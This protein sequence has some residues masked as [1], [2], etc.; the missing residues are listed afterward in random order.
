M[1]HTGIEG[2]VA[3]VT[4]A[5]QGIGRAVARALAD[6][7]ASVAALDLAEE[8]LRAA[9]AEI[10]SAGGTA[11]AFPCDV[12]DPA[13]VEEAFEAA[14]RSL[15]PVRHAVSVAGVLRTGPGAATTDADWAELV[16]VNATG[17]FH[18]LRA[19]ARRM[20]A[21]GAGTITTVGSNAADTPRADLAA[22]GASKAAAASFTRALGV[23][24]APLGVR[25]NV[26]SPGSTDTPMQRGMWAGPDGAAAVIAGAPDRFRTGIPLG[27][28]ADPVDIAAA[29]RFLA[30]D[31]AR[32]I[33]LHDL[34]VDGGATPR[35]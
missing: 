15:G 10:A 26:V 13:A 16:A 14:E 21:R 28:L 17:A 25:C 6:A 4:G 33:T 31:E 20:S 29:V 23:E 34:R 35:S 19:A 5:A 27:R 9:A 12:R 2:T 1:S 18:V 24:L 7:G 11:R 30:S 3:L 8:P 22:Y 32:H